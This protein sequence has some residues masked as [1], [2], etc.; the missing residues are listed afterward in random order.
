MPIN[1]GKIFEQDFKSCLEEQV[2]HLWVYRP[3]D[4][5]GG[6]ASRFT[7]HS[8]CDYIVFDKKNSE[9]YFFEL[10]STKSTSISA[11]SH[12]Q[13]EALKSLQEASFNK[14][15]EEFKQNKKD[16]L[17]A[18]KE[19]L[20]RMNAN[21]IKYHQILSLMNIEKENIFNNMHPY[22]ILDFREKN[23]TFAIKPSDLCHM[24]KETGKSSINIIDLE[25]IGIEISR[26]QKKKG[27]HVL[28]DVKNLLYDITKK[29]SKI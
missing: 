20:K 7:N 25:N 5:G 12:T 2:P 3:S 26:E 23:K 14:A 15:E 9:L 28:Y 22:F 6:Q 19:L 4:F 10:K 21:N 18:Q 11:P 8:L 1:A 17:N 29:D 13:Y 27:K 16:A 24:L